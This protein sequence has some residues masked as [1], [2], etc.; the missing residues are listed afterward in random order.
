MGDTIEEVLEMFLHNWNNN[1]FGAQ[2]QIFL[3]SIHKVL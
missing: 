1:T 2:G 3:Y